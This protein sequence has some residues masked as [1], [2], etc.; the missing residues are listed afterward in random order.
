ML[1]YAAVQINPCGHLVSPG[2]RVFST[3]TFR[4]VLKKGS[5]PKTVGLA[6]DGYFQDFTRKLAMSFKS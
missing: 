4:F 3:S 1:C 2:F 5:P 6:S